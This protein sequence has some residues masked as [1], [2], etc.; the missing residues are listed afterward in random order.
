MLELFGSI[1]TEL[2]EYDDYEIQNNKK[3]KISALN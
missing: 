2:Q 3:K 1:Q